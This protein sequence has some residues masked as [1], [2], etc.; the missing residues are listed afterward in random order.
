MNLSQQYDSN[1]VFLISTD[2]ETDDVAAIYL[3]SLCIP[4][5]KIYFLVGE[6]DRDIKYERMKMYIKMIGFSNAHVLYGLPSN[7]KFTFDGYDVFTPQTNIKLPKCNLSMEELYCEIF[8]ALHQKP[9]IISLK[10]PRELITIYMRYPDFFKDLTIYG[11]MSFNL[12]CLMKDY[13]KANI[14]EFFESF[15]ETY[16]YET[17]HAIGSDNI[18]TGKDI[19]M[20]AMPQ[21]ISGIMKYWNKHQVEYSKG[22][23]SKLEG[24]EDARSKSR[25]HRNQ[26]A[27]GQVVDND[28]LQFV[29]ADTGLIFSMI[30]DSGAS[31]YIKRTVSFDE[32]GYS[33]I[34]P[35]DKI[36]VIQPDNKEDYN[37][38]QKSML[39]ELLFDC[40]Y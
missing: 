27:I 28:Y 34:K 12:R 9:V 30:D 8:R 2:L 5:N 17:Y 11:Y 7:K 26:K 32:R 20:N 19:D 36:Y 39:R 35:G 23:C 24:K 31:K 22:V 4:D 25:Y 18:I 21:V 16:W 10:P 29:N 3:L 6:G 15:K 1:T 14:I 38:Y 13:I 37:I 33:V 40:C